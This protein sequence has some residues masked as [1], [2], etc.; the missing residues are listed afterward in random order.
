MNQMNRILKKIQS[1]EYD[2]EVKEFIIKELKWY[3]D[4]KEELLK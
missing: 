2:D 1:R 4:H 3:D